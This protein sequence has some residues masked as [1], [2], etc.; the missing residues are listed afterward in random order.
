MERRKGQETEYLLFELSDDEK[1]REA[2]LGYYQGVLFVDQ[3]ASI[4]S[5]RSED[6]GGQV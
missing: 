4:S 5:P 2:E 6:T 1:R 3:G